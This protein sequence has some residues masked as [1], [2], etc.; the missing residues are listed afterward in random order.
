MCWTIPHFPLTV[1]GASTRW[2]LL[3]STR[4]SR[5][6]RHRAFTSPSRRYSH[7]LSRSICSSREELHTAAVVA[8]TGAAGADWAEAEV[9]AETEGAPTDAVAAGVGGATA[10][11]AILA[12]TVVLVL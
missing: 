12:S 2:T 7:R 10:A 4:I 3:S 9:E 6:R 8:A 5:A 1:T 11:D